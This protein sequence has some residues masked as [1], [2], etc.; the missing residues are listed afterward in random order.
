[1]RDKIFQTL[2]YGGLSNKGAEAQVWYA[3]SVRI[4]RDMGLTR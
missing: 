3:S 4:G 2:T 1:M